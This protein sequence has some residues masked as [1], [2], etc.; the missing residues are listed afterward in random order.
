MAPAPAEGH[1]VMGPA[2]RHVSCHSRNRLVARLALILVFA[3]LIGAA[4]GNARVGLA[5]TPQGE[6]WADGVASFSSSDHLQ[7]WAQEGAGLDAA[8]FLTRY[9]AAAELA[10]DELA[11]LFPTGA[12]NSFTLYL[13][14]DE[15][16]FE[17]DTAGLERAF[18]DANVVADPADNSLAVSLALFAARTPREAENALRHAIAH[19]SLAEASGGNAPRGIDEGIA[20]YVERP[21]SPRLA[22]MAALVQSA[23]QGGS[24]LSWSDINRPQAPTADPELVGAQAYSM[25]GFLIDRYGIRS[26]RDYLTAVAEEPDWRAA[27]RTAYNRS[28]DEMERQWRDQLPRWA[29]GGWK[30]NLV[31]GFDLQPATD[32]LASA[33]YA[34]AK[35]ELER[36]QRLFTELGDAERL[37]AV[38]DLL[39][40]VDTGIQAEALMAQ[41]QQALEHHTYD[42][43]QQLLVQA[44]GQYER[45]P[46]AQQPLELLQTYEALAETG[47]EATLALDEARLLS[48]RWGDY[49]LARR[50]TV[51]AGTSFAQLSDPEMTSEARGLLGELD[52]RQRRLVMLLLALVILTAAW[53]GLWLWARGPSELD[54]R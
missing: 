9:G 40:Q 16:A 8:T 41:A 24:L 33:N 7:V 31:A 43:A 23:N 21:V 54:W 37:T 53:L 26:F 25:I 35:T 20:L 1:G 3:P 38:D 27:M 12:T 13:Y 47:M 22:R 15:S 39:A 28:P 36:S 18:A 46:E 42:R 44:R 48:H 45:L 30:S 2:A 6:S 52:G 51:D 5:A 50:S 29:A 4:F 10:Y 34:T 32:L 17:A 19:L 49:A 11:S 14:A